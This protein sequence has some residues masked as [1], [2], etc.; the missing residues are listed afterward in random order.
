MGAAGYPGC[1]AAPICHKP[2]HKS[3]EMNYS[4]T[5]AAITKIINTLLN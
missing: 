2:T 1:V 3:L 5:N 4:W